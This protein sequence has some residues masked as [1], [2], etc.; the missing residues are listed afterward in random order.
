M[1]TLGND[2]AARGKSLIELK[3]KAIKRFNGPK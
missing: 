2:F 1:R 3:A